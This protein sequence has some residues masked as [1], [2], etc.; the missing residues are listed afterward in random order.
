MN[1]GT[2]LGIRVDRL[3]QAASALD[4][5]S[6]WSARADAVVHCEE[7]IPFEERPSV[8]DVSI[9]TKYTGR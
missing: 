9:D 4:A 8:E 3:S 7:D 6:K 2:A 5:A 1:D